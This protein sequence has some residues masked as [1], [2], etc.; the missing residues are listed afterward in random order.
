M[1]EFQRSSVEQGRYY[2]GH[3]RSVL[4]IRGW[5]MVS[6]RPTK[7]PGGEVDVMANDPDGVLHWIECKGSYKDRPGLLRDDTAKKAIAVAWM[8]TR[9]NPNRPRYIVITSDLP[10]V[11]SL[12][13][14]Y[15]NEALEAGIID[16]VMEL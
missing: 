13:A 14:T 1:T 5:T 3:V 2:E 6:E 12:A 8:L 16:G 10:K 11:G 4:A 15:I 7:V 9:K